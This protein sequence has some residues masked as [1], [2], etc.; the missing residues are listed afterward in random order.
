MAAVWAGPI[1]RQTAALAW[2]PGRR[3]QAWV[4]SA[5]MHRSVRHEA[6]CPDEF[7][8]SGRSFRQVVTGPLELP[9]PTGILSWAA[10]VQQMRVFT[11]A[12][13]RRERMRQR[14]CRVTLP[15][16]PSTRGGH[17]RR[18]RR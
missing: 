8:A 15:A 9:S 6:P 4:N 11:P 7:A 16:Q 17:H 5:K 18:A 10:A 12:I 13:R 2:Q 14:L 3:E 1:W